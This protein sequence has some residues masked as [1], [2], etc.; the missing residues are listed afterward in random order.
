MLKT[1]SLVR[2]QL[3]GRGGSTW[4]GLLAWLAAV[5]Q[6]SGTVISWAT[7]LAARHSNQ[8]AEVVWCAGVRL[9][10]CRTFPFSAAVVWRSASLGR[11]P[12]L[13]PGYQRHSHPTGTRDAIEFP[14]RL[15][16]SII[17]TFHSTSNTNY[18]SYSPPAFVLH[19]SHVLNTI[20]HHS[21]FSITVT[22]SALT[23]HLSEVVMH[24]I[25]SPFRV[26]CIN[27]IT[28]RPSLQCFIKR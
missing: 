20:H 8:F 28:L 17:F 4:P 12:R 10:F 23:V 14:W 7:P 6:V 11:K 19:H 15:F 24:G 5:D 16:S 9:V 21:C 26:S 18:Y 25:F 2:Q 1:C 27:W 13:A 22:S 3:V